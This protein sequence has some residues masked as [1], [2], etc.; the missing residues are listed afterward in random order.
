MRI[1]IDLRLPTYRMGGISQ[2]AIY[3]LRGLAE[4]EGDEEFLVY[5]SR[6]ES[7]SFL[8]AGPRFARR[9]LWTPCHHRVERYA[10]AA[11]LSSARLDVFHSPDFIPPAG[12]ARRRVI[13]VHDLTFLRY[14][15][16]LTAESRRYYNDQIHWAVEQADA[17]SADSE[18]TRRDL[19]E[20]VGTQPEKV[21]TIH[22][23]ANPVYS[24]PV[25]A[26]EITA[27]RERYG[28]QPGFILHVGTLEPRKNIPTLLRAYRRWREE[29]GRANLL[30]LVG[31]RGWLFDEIFASIREQGLED[32]V[33]HLSGVPDAHLAHLYRSASVLVAPS[34]YEGFG[35]PPLEAMHAGCPV[36][37]SDCGSLPEVVGEAGMLLDPAD[38][39]AW[40]AALETVIGDEAVAARMRASGLVQAARFTWRK[41][42]ESTLR[43]Y[44]GE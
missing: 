14:P 16:F 5:H 31:G 15:Q 36:I 1:G 4:L 33:R 3:L 38:D 40:A 13:T 26:E 21:T 18:A 19:I 34:F 2:Y 37:A 10:L 8:P 32:S 11:E 7:R 9:A 41:T 42:A 28:L 6:K 43:L 29:T 44:H 35:L 20:L 25:S 24:A 27:T 23:A 17:I 12:G 22:L 39:L 30:L